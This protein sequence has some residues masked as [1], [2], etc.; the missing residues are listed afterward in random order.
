M[1]SPKHISHVELIDADGTTT[2]EEVLS[3]HFQNL[4]VDDV[5]GLDRHRALH[6]AVKL[7]LV[8]RLF[9]HDRIFRV[10]TVERLH[11]GKDRL[12]NK[13]TAIIEFT[14]AVECHR[15]VLASS[16]MEPPTR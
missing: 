10:A 8:S 16:A 7:D 3:A 6:H 4:K 14:V 9:R 15:G 12:K 2:L 5:I 13:Y 1:N 11:V